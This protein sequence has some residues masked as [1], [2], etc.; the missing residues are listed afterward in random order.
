MY[1]QFNVV[2]LDLSV[3]FLFQR[4]GQ[5]LR[6]GGH[7]DVQLE[8]FEKALHDSSAGLTYTALSGVCKQSVEDVERLFGDSVINW[9]EIKGYNVEAEYLRVICNWRRACDER[10]LSYAQQSQFNNNLLKYVLDELMPLHMKDRLR[11]FSLLEV[12]RYILYLQ[13]SNNTNIQK[14]Q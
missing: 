6:Q 12:N 10:G 7:V 1:I 2:D 14:Y 5:S 11:D 9:M 8:R 13:S 4:I 3:S